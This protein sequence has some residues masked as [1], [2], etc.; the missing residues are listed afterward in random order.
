MTVSRSKKGTVERLI[1]DEKK[2]EN[3]K[4]DIVVS[5]GYISVSEE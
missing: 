1:K 2:K 4:Y 3:I 5:V